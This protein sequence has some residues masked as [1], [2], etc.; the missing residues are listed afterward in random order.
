MS[1]P[2][3]ILV[4]QA[5]GHTAVLQRWLDQMRLGDDAAFR[6]ARD[7]AINHACGRLEDLTR[8]MLRRFPQLRRWEQ[9]GDVL[10]NAVL[11]LHR[12]LAAVRPE[13]A[14]QF[15][16]LAATQIRRELIDLSR[17]HFGPEGAAAR[18]HTDGAPKAHDHESAAAQATD[19][20]GEPDS[21]AGWAEFHEKV[22]TLPETEREVFDLLW[23]EGLSQSEAAALLGVTERTIKNRWRSA[24]LLLRR[25]LAES[26]E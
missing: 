24:K 19:P 16:G 13:S 3:G 11:R 23:Y 17:H 20:T 9:T 10:Q 5:E 12:S 18:H 14:R 15:Y 4:G 22:H 1:S 6:N 26:P 25:L 21:L 8:R 7:Q 2:K